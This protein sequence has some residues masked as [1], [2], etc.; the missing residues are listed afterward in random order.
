MHVYVLYIY[1]SIYP[2][3]HVCMCAC[4]YVCIY[5]YLYAHITVHDNCTMSTM[6]LVRMNI[7]SL[8]VL[9]I[10]VSVLNKP[11]VVMSSCCYDCSSEWYGYFH[12]DSCLQL[13]VLLQ[14]VLVWLPMV[15]S[16]I[17]NVVILGWPPPR[18]PEACRCICSQEDGKSPP[19]PI[20]W[21]WVSVQSFG[22]GFKAFSLKNREIRVPY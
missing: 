13:V 5:I 7:I 12:C 8:V 14:L 17:A 21:W 15:T 6:I 20:L 2:C 10:A 19:Y 3:M 22:L 1:L 4:M 16:T 11:F 9:M 18:A